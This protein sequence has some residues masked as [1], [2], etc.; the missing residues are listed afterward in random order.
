M[1]TLARARAV[2]NQA[3]VAVCNRIGVSKSGLDFGGSSGIWSPDGASLTPA[4]DEAGVIAAEVDLNEV[5]RWRRELP[6]LQ[7]RVR[8]VDYE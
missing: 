8:H 2:E 7:S 1:Q 4:L 5:E 3:Y 6:I